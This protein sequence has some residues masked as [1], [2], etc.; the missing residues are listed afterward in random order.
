M[1]PTDLHQRALL[2]HVL[3]D[4]LRLGNAAP[5]TL[6]RAAAACAIRP[7]TLKA[8]STSMICSSSRGECSLQN[9]GQTSN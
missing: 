5:S 6:L 8:L 9:M 1:Q 7:P 4:G 2:H 3:S